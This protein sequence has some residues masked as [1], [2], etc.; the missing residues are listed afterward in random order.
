[1][2][3]VFC[4]L[5]GADARAVAATDALHAFQRP[6]WVNAVA[7]SRRRAHEFV[8]VQARRTGAPDAFLFGGEHQR[9][10]LRVFESMPMMGYGGWV[11]A[12]PM[13]LGVEQRLMRDWLAHCKWP[14]VE[15]TS[16]PGRAAALP[17]VD[18]RWTKAL[19]R[20]LRS[21]DTQ[22]HCLDLTGDTA[23]L[24]ART[25]PNVRSYLRRH[26]D[27]GF[28]CRVGSRECLVDFLRWYRGGSQGWRVEASHL[29]PD[30][31][32]EALCE[33]DGADVWVVSAAGAQ[34]GAAVFLLGRRD[35]FYLASGTERAS[36]PISAM[37]VLVWSAALHYR[38]RGFVSLNLGASEGLDSVAR[39]KRKF[40][41]TEATYRRNSYLLP[42]FIR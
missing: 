23:A 20:R 35:V 5:R 7:R 34:V 28:S 24:I 19:P 11:C 41:A 40:G 1:M 15:V 22:T 26:G 36:G 4:V 6:Q 21:A 33:G 42:R 37:D 17:S 12:E 18:S 29:Y 2:G 3:N 13:D 27:F 25:K 10:G 38:E 14:L 16:S 31:F 32:F 9:L 30:A 39:F 8:V